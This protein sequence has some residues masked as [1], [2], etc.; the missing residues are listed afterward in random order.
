MHK[1]WQKADKPLCQNAAVPLALPDAAGVVLGP[2][3][4]GVS[5]VIEGARKDLVHVALQDLHNIVFESVINMLSHNVLAP[6]L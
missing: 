2:C 3:N 6:V 4:D 1:H 5:L